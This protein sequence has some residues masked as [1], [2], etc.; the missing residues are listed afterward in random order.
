MIK[1]DNYRIVQLDKWNTTFEVHREVENKKTKE[2]EFKW[3]QE[4]GYYGDVQSALI[5]L[6]NYIIAN[7][8][9]EKQNVNLLN[10]LDELNGSIVNCKLLANEV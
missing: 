1:L 7:V 4:G 10:F 3:V 2:K 9:K 6:K 8:V 5:A